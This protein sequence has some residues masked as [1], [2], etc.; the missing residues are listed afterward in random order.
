M[1][2]SAAVSGFTP[3]VDGFPFT[4]SFPP[5][6]A[7]QLDLGPAGRVGIGDVSGGVCGGMVFAVRDYFETATAIPQLSQPPAPGTPLF[8]YIV[9]RLLDSW[10]VPNGVLRY[11]QWMALP[12]THVRLPLISEPGTFELT[13]SK[14]W[15]AIRADI[16]AGRLSTL[17]LVTVHGTDLKQLGKNHQV[18][19]YGY[20][21]DDAGALTLHVYDPN[22]P[23][24]SADGVVIQLDVSDPSTVT[25]ISHNI[26]IGEP[27]LHGFFRADYARKNPPTDTG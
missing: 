21:L 23:T 6:P 7:V 14:S 15:P 1:S 18:L 2:S 24:D 16:D 12:S 22:T 11:A 5:A 17:G 25:T 13:V 27:T 26:N 10:D 3:S 4:N 20:S 9:G 8:E 19:A